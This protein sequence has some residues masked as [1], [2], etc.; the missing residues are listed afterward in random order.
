MALQTIKTKT[1]SQILFEEFMD[2]ETLP[3]SACERVISDLNDGYFKSYSMVV[4]RVRNRLSSENISTI[5]GVT[6]VDFQYRNKEVDL[7]VLVRF[8]N[9]THCKGK[10]FIVVNQEDLVYLPSGS[11]NNYSTNELVEYVSSVQK[12]HLKQLKKKELVG[13]IKTMFTANHLTA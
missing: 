13:K 9:M 12:E 1:Q 11:K 7:P 4:N 2:G 8:L 10:M 3:H 5:K 6:F